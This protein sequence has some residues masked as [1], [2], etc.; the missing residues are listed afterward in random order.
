MAG[1]VITNCQQAVTEIQ[2]ESMKEKLYDLDTKR[3]TWN[4]IKQVNCKVLNI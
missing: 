2:G 1:N 3:D 4:T